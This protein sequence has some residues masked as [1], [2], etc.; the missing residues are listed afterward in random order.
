VKA[1]SRSAS[2]DH[3]CAPR[4][5]GACRVGGTTETASPF[6]SPPGSRLCHWAPSPVEQWSLRHAPLAAS[7]LHAARDRPFRACGR[8]PYCSRPFRAK[9]YVPSTPAGIPVGCAPC[10][11]PRIG[12]DT[13]GHNPLDAHSGRVG[14]RF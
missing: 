4:A 14:A 12:P 13:S 11:L 6:L 8:S 7:A 10:G 1:L 3:R 2:R 5:C 9:M